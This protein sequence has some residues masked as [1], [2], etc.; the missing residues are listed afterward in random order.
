MTGELLAVTAII[1][2]GILFN[3]WFAWA[4]YYNSGRKARSERILY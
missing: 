4:V 1:F 3:I 2:G